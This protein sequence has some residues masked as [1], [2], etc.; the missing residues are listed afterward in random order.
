MSYPDAAI[1]TPDGPSLRSEILLL[2]ALSLLLVSVVSGSLAYHLLKTRILEENTAD[3][4]NI[5]DNRANLIYSYLTMQTDHLIDISQSHEAATALHQLGRSYRNGIDSPAYA[6]QDALHRPHLE[7]FADRWHFADILLINR[8]GDVIFTLAHERDFAS[9]LNTGPYRDTGLAD[10]FRQSLQSFS[11]RQSGFQFYQPAH[12]T[13]AFMAV[14]VIHDHHLWGVIAVQLNTDALYDIAGN[15]AGLGKSGEIVMGM[16]STEGVIVTAPLRGDP[17]AA[18][19]RIIRK[20]TTMG[21]PILEA[22]Q[23]KSGQGE[24]RDWRNIDVVAAWTFIPG[25]NWGIVAKIDRSEALARLLN[26]RNSLFAGLGIITLLTLFGVALYSRRITRPLV[27]LA[28]TAEAMSSGRVTSYL[29][30][31]AASNRETIILS[32]SFQ[33]MSGEILHYQ[34]GLEEEVQARTA[35]L[36]RLQ[37]A[38]EH[39]DN[40]IMITNR[41]AIIEYV[42]P[43]FE[44]I[45]G[46]ASAF[47]VG[48]PASIVKSGKM[49]YAFYQKMWHTILSGQNWRAIFINRNRA[50]DEYEVEQVISPISNDEGQITGFV[51]VQR[52][53]TQERLQQKRQEHSQ[54]LESLGVLAGGIAHDFNNLLTTIMGNAGLARMHTDDTS[55]VAA[56]LEYI[57]QASERAAELCKQMLAYSGK[58]SFVIETINLSTLIRSIT[59]LLQVS[60][61]KNVTLRLELD[62]Q[63]PHIDADSAQMQQVVM[64]L[65]INASEAIGEENGNIIIHTGTIDV[66]KAYAQSNLINDALPDGR[67][68]FMD[69]SDT[70]CGMD[71][72]TLDKL[73]DPFFTTKFT[74]RGLGMSAI[75]GIIRGHQGAIK[76][77]SEQGKGSRFKILLPISAEQSAATPDHRRELLSQSWKGNGRIL[78]VDDEAG[79][80]MIATEMLHDIGFKTSTAANGE[81]AVE[82]FRQEYQD[83]TAVLLDMTMPKMDGKTAFREMRRIQPDVKVILSSGYNEQDATSQFAGKGLAGFIQKP[84]SIE[85][86]R[87]KLQSLL[88][89]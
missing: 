32:N 70:G 17:D 33:H 47:A 26:I 73:Y 9:N 52:N 49:D 24:F 67:Y 50:G 16:R 59:D 83:I 78:V 46:F 74:G 53:V 81:E 55:P 84:Y 19:K 77:Y 11:P 86:L 63:L 13:A 36:V 62:E 60:I 23:G 54:R 6:Q 68:I 35:D 57:E 44:R 15:L 76:V 29:E 21:T 25:L 37:T 31:V 38:I 64:N 28:R 42:N 56:N 88:G 69:I 18:F 79:I 71:K 10:V 12:A 72:N 61:S 7:A 43:A 5:V 22:T 2:C 4:R 65:I 82:L 3:Q 40:I 8:K 48:R 27:Q 1:N 34:R 75:L 30:P 80:R 89:E 85:L 45:S 14:P 51:S 66:D 87:Q 39:T 41:D 58:G 20:D